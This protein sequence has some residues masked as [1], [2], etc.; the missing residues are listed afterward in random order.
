MHLNIFRISVLDMS[1]K[2][3]LSEEKLRSLVQRVLQLMSAITTNVDGLDQII[4]SE[5]QDVKDSQE[6]SR[7]QIRDDLVD[8]KMHMRE[9]EILQ[10]SIADHNH[11]SNEALLQWRAELQN[12][13]QALHSCLQTQLDLL[14]QQKSKRIP[15]MHNS[16]I[17]FS[18]MLFGVVQVI[19]S[20]IASGIG[21]MATL[22]F[23]MPTPQTAPSTVSPLFDK[24]WEDAYRA[25][26]NEYAKHNSTSSI[27]AL[28]TTDASIIS[29]RSASHST[30]TS[31]CW[32][33]C[34]GCGDG[35]YS[36]FITDC[37]ACG[38]LWCE[39]CVVDMKS[40]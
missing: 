13:V 33:Y 24:A 9:V 28:H 20:G 11:A 21:A 22:S 10:R 8:M 31:K 38:H 19:G 14:L 1:R 27:A 2:T 3:A 7:T 5:M 18:Q 40:R 37:C 12:S 25:V 16:S 30:P 39:E 35:P 34:H 36:D 6:A 23:H 26:E 29:P 17:S 4:R 15:E 32:W